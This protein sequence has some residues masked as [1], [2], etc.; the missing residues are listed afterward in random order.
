VVAELQG[1]FD[2]MVAWQYPAAPRTSVAK[3]EW[4]IVVGQQDGIMRTSKTSDG[5]DM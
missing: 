2:E 1:G 5:I 4:A 3:K